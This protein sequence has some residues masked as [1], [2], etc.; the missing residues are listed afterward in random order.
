MS[1]INNKYLDTVSKKIKNISMLLAY[2]HEK[3]IENQNIKRMIYYNNRNPLS[4]KGLTYAG[5]RVDQPDLTE[6]DVEDLIT[7]LPFNPK[8]NIKTVSSI[9][10]NIPMASF[11]TTENQIYI[12]V[13]IVTPI[14]YFEITNGVR[15]YEIAHEVV[16]I[17]D[18]LCVEDETYEL[19]NARFFF[20]DIVIERLSNNS[21][22][23][24]ASMRFK[25]DILPFN[26]TRG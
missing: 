3:I 5:E 7:M 16:N 14:Q 15:L 19:G 17:F 18:R 9:F 4:K 11:Y 10:L 26:K 13:D 25:A 12:E 22:M 1:D 2:V 8:M 6:K 20:E 24:C 23:T 21:D